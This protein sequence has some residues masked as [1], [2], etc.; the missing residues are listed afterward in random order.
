LREKSGR[1]KIRGK[2]W[3]WPGYNGVIKT[4]AIGVLGSYVKGTLETRGGK[5][6]PPVL[7]E[8][9]KGSLRQT[10]IIGGMKQVV[11]RKKKGLHENPC[12]KSFET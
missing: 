6:A 11:L 1:W 5:R 12:K 7:L 8:R 3:K 4:N 10:I 2:G 9:D